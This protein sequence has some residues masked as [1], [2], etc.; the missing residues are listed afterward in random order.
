ME[1][2]W[3]KQKEILLE[4]LSGKHLTV[5]RTLL[6]NQR[7]YLQET[8]A[9]TATGTSN[10]GRFDLVAMPLVRRVTPAVVATNL[11]GI[12]PMSAP[13]GI[14]NTLRVR[15]AQSV[16]TTNG[17]GVNAV[18]AGTEA[19]GVNIYEK[20]SLLASGEAYDAADS[21]TDWNQTLALESQG[22]NQM[23]LDVVTQ[24][25]GTKTRKLQAKWSIEAA[26]DAQALHNIDIE[27]ELVAA[28]ADE[29]VREMDRELLTNLR[30]LAGTVK[31]FDFATA[32]GRYAGEKFTALSIGISDLSNQIAIKTKRGRATW[33][34]VSPNVYTALSHSNSGTFVPG[35]LD[36]G[37]ALFVG[38]YGGNVQV[39][40][41]L[42]Q[43]TDEILLGY[44]GS[45]ELD[46]G[47]VYSPYIPVMQSDRIVDPA[48]YNN[49]IGL[50]T[51]YALTAFT[52]TDTSLGNSADY[53]ARGTVSNLTLGFG[54]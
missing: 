16:E 36:V 39:Y 7:R 52:D 2:N 6:E 4:G 44:K 17:S 49:Q 15:Y 32:D 25:I 14:V 53:Y 35:T 31:A 3:E 42:Y 43:T 20:Y 28:M 23:N 34:V 29:I 11:V 9:T 5:T 45:S 26:Q 47:Y 30:N 33:M 10:I 1:N 18:T 40:L 27:Q 8:A 22:G 38:T 24:N 12:Q 37:S 54:S 13:V 46:T 21:R 51:R 50:L 19:N 41:D 48:T